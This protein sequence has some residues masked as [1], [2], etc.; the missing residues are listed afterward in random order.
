LPNGRHAAER[1]AESGPS[2]RAPYSTCAVGRGLSRRN[3][4]VR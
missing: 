1:R 3:G 2:P 4:G